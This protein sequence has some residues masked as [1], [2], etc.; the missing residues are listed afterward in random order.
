LRSI[1]L[2]LSLCCVCFVFKARFVV[3]P[4]HSAAPQH[5]HPRGARRS[6]V[7]FCPS[8]TEGASAPGRHGFKLRCGKGSASMVNPASG[9]CTIRFRQEPPRRVLALIRVGC[10]RIY[11][12]RRCRK[13]GFE[14]G[15][16]WLTGPY[17]WR[18]GGGQEYA[19]LC[20]PRWLSSFLFSL[21]AVMITGI[22]YLF[23]FISF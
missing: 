19:F 23:H 16:F 15:R 7:L 22:L 10:W 5:R 4:P 17:P 12:R 13:H 11:M 9:G 8:F 2:P 6:S 14:E 20:L 1:P 3:P 21:R 18:R